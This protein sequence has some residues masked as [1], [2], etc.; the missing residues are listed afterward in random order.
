[1]KKLIVLSSVL[2]LIFAFA[3]TAFAQAPTLDFK[4][5]G[6]IDAQTFW[7]VNTTAGNPGAGVY[8]T[9]S[10]LPAAFNADGTTRDPIGKTVSFWESR[11]RLKFDARMGKEL[12]GTIQ[13]EIDAGPWGTHDAAGTR[14]NAG[15]WTADR[16]AVEVKHFYF[17]FGVPVVP[18]PISVRIGQQ[19]LYVRPNFF[20]NNDGMAITA[21]IKLDPVTISPYYAK[22]VENNTEDSDDVDVY[23]LDVKAKLGPVTIGGYGFWYNMNTYPLNAG[24]AKTMEAEMLWLGLYADGKLGPVN[25]NFDFGYDRGEVENIVNPAIRAVKYRGWATMLKVDFPWDKFNFGFMGAYGSGVDTRK[26]SATGLPGTATSSGVASTKVS[27]FVV[28][29]GTEVAPAFGE[30]MVFFS[31]FVNRG[32]AAIDIALNGNQL[33]RG[34]LGG[35]WFAKLYASLKATPWY[36][37][38]LQG[39]YIGDTTKNG[40]TF[41]TARNAPWG[42]ANLKDD[43][44]IGWELDL[45][46]EI[47]IYKNLKFMIGGGY[48]WA[49]K[50]MDLYTNNAATG[51]YD[52]KNPWSVSTNIT[53]NF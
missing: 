50:A 10:G 29:P 33:S 41:G 51:N 13:F 20:L 37:I 42:A 31:S 47:W 52:P 7:F 16:A 49:G 14:N 18:V 22:A 38:T 2:L 24:A 48:L 19:G 32:D 15:F 39:F 17:D 34:H 35:L 25:L 26:T 21:G 3:A 9:W 28:P 53:Y 46:N 12:S 6:L 30:G 8:N 1:M 27:S 5:S 36:K 45:I 43:K 4:A 23:G 40:N 11:A 44:S